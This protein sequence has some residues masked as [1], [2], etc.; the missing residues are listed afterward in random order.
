MPDLVVASIAKGVVLLLATAPGHFDGDPTLLAQVSL[1]SG[2]AHASSASEVATF[3]H[4]E[5]RT[6]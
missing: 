6:P 5:R 2:S 1:I 3:S 4:G